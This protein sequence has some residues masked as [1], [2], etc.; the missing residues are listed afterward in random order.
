MIAP[1]DPIDQDALRVRHEFLDMPGLIVSVPQVARL[2]GLRSEHA[3]AI[4]E[5]LEREHF[6]AQTPTGAYHLA[7]SQS[8]RPTES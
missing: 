1:G 6:L 5:T 3:C 8:H 2:F 4:L 7:P